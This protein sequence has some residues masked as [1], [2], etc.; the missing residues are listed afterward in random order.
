MTNGEPSMVVK[1]RSSSDAIAKQEKA[2]V[3]MPGLANKPITIIEGAR[4]DPVIIK[5]GIIQP[6]SLPENL[7]TFGLVFKP[8]IA[9]VKR[10]RKL[11][12]KVWALP[13]PISRLSRSFVK[14]GVRKCLVTIV[15][16]RGTP[17]PAE[18]G[19][20]R[21]GVQGMRGPS[22]F[23]A[24]RSLQSSKASPDVVTRILTVQSHDVYA[25]IDLS[26]TLLY[27]TPYVAMEFG[28]EPEQLHEL[29]SV[30]TLVGESTMAARMDW[31][32]SCFP[33]LDC[34]TRTVRFEFPN[35][36]VIEWKGD[37]VVPNGVTSIDAKAHTLESLPVVNEFLDVFPDE[38]PGIP[39]DNEIGF[40][41]DVMLDMKPIS[42]PPY[43]MASTVLKELKN[44]LKDLFEKG[45]SGRVSH[46]RLTS[47]L[48]KEERWGATY[49]SKIDL[50]SGYQQLKIREQDIPKI[51]FRPGYGHFKFLVMSFG[52]I[53]APAA[54]M[55]LM[56]RF[57]KPFLDYFEIVFIDDILVYSRSREDHV[58]H[59]R[60]V[61]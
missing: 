18:R 23:Y 21:G 37:D 59:L 51:P 54:F 16:T 17:I 55:D 43:R 42:I 58:D 27:V 39:Q 28:I 19:A 61:L 35:E 13:K 4:T 26:S 5:P 15:P 45:L 57:F 10:A 6:V 47:S 38:L 36:P 30:S 25:L 29:F 33:K 20:A 3:V 11:K 48:C 46:L 7:G 56:N 44:Q 53:N 9:D 50:R 12:Q 2:K 1:K 31:H 49:L 22:Y 32:Y 8:T 14:P 52:I 60:A 41:I 40:G 34:R 24:M